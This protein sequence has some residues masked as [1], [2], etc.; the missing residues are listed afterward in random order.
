LTAQ[1]KTEFEIVPDPIPREHYRY[2]SQQRW[3]FLVR[4]NGQPVRDLEVRLQ[5]S[6]GT[7]L[8]TTS[9]AEGRVVFR[10]PDDF[11]DLVEGERDRRLSQF[12]ASS[13]YIQE[14]KRYTTQLNADYRI[15]PSHWQSTPWGLLVIGVGFI[16]GGFIGR[17]NNPGGKA[18]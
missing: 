10:I 17:V 16:A 4:F 18:K 5:T 3:G 2:H 11:P 14:D 12:T 7:H 15:N 6:N 9:D 13:E 1:Q 8:S